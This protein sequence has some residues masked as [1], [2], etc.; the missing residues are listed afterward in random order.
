[1][2]WISVKDRLPDTNTMVQGY[3]PDLAFTDERDGSRGYGATRAAGVRHCYIRSG[4]KIFAPEGH[5]SNKSTIT[6][7]MP[8][9][10][11]PKQP[12]EEG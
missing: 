3:D 6:H 11:P 4:S 12:S 2:D 5:N 10:E 8:L 7:W 9:P 1:M